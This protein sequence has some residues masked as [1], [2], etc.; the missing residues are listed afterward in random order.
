MKTCTKCGRTRR[1]AE[2]YR[3]SAGRGGY[4]AECKECVRTR[5][6]AR[7]ACAFPGCARPRASEPHCQAHAHQRRMGQTLRPIRKNDGT[8]WV[9]ANGYRELSRGRSRRVLEHRTVMEQTLKRSLLS[10]ESVHH[11][12]GVKDD[13]RPENLE[14]WSTAQPTGQRVEDLLAWAHEVIERYE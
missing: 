14:L 12:N 8:G 13:N 2:F 3:Q 7:P 4:A 10:G 5:Q 11:K 1:L 9:T 6:S